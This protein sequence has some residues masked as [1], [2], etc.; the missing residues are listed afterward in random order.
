[1]SSFANPSSSWADD[2]A[3]DPSLPRETSSTEHSGS[4]IGEGAVGVY[5]PHGV[6]PAAGSGVDVPGGGTDGEAAETTVSVDYEM[7]VEVPISTFNFLRLPYANMSLIVFFCLQLEIVHTT[8]SGVQF[9]HNLSCPV[10]S[11]GFLG[12]AARV[13]RCGPSS[14]L[15]LLS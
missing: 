15:Q 2:D 9:G 13:E 7:H 11:A 14:K 5:P 1:M 3:Y 4:Q 12:F 6:A 10:H 8:R